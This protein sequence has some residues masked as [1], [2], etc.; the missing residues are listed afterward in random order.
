MP[1]A[2]PR[3]QR[4]AKRRWYRRG[5]ATGRCIRCRETATVG[6]R[7]AA[8]AELELRPVPFCACG[9]RLQL[10]RTELIYHARCTYCRGLKKRR[11]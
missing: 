3:Q 2:D 7:C 8:H 5:K 10:S 6:L 9:T 4:E 1:Y 11:V